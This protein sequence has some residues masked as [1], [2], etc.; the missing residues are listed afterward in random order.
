MLPLIGILLAILT[1]V[2]LSLID[3]AR[4]PD[5]ALF[6]LSNGLLRLSYHYSDWYILLLFVIYCSGVVLL[7]LR[8]V[9][10]TQSLNCMIFFIPLLV[11]LNLFSTVFDEMLFKPVYFIPYYLFCVGLFWVAWQTGK[12][13]AS[14]QYSMVLRIFNS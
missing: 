3:I 8:R 5:N 12:F 9:I 14:N 10:A 2:W 7:R 13:M 4:I 6:E 11:V 1:G